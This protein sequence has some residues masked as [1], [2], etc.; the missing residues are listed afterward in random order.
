MSRPP[1]SILPGPQHAWRGKRI[2]QPTVAATRMA[3]LL[4]LVVLTLALVACVALPAP[5]AA[6]VSTPTPSPSST[7]QPTLSATPSP[8][9]TPQSTKTPTATIPPWLLLLPTTVTPDLSG[10]PTRVTLTPA[11]TSTVPVELDCSLNWQSPANNVSFEPEDE[12]AVGWSVTNSG[13]AAWD[14]ESVIFTYLGGAKLHRYPT[15]ELKADVDPGDTVVL[16]VDMR[17]PRNA[18]KYTTYWSLRRGEV[19]FCRLALSIYVG[20]SED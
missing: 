13:S 10:L 3:R 15:V 16:S 1:K 2:P 17:A 4:L 14:T 7:A 12:I 20:M 6:L 8:S 19:F 9:A 11:P 5:L 18:T